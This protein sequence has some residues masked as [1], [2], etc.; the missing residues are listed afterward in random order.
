[1]R[2]P[3]TEDLGEEELAE[4]ITRDSLIGVNVPRS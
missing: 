1:M 2:P 3:D 4:L